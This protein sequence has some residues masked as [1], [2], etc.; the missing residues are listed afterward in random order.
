[1]TETLDQFIERRAMEILAEIARMTDEALKAVGV[2]ASTVNR[3][4]GQLNRHAKA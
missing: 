3:R 4:R 2:P 1:M